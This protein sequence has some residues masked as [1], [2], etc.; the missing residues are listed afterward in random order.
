MFRHLLLLIALA[1]TGL[2]SA[3]ATGLIMPPYG[4]TRAQ[5][6]AAIAAARKVQTIVVLSSDDGPGSRKDTFI[7]G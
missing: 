5:F 2:G 6:N 1:G 3:Q 7:A 4:N